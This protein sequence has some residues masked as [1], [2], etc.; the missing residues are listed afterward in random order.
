MRLREAGEHQGVTYLDLHNNTEP[1]TEQ[2]N[3]PRTVMR[4]DELIVQLT[5]L[6]ENKPFPG[7]VTVQ[8]NSMWDPLG[9]ILPKEEVDRAEIINTLALV[10]EVDVRSSLALVENHSKKQWL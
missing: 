10:D 8:Q 1:T 3:S 6:D 9:L 7:Q 2:L 4:A 5:H